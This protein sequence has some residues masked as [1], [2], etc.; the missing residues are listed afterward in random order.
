MLWSLWGYTDGLSRRGTTSSP[1]A[2]LLNNDI[3]TAFPTSLHFDALQL[4]EWELAPPN[5]DIIIASPPF[6]LLDPFL[7]EFLMRA[8]LFVCIHTPSDYI[9]N[10]PTYRRSLWNWYQEAGLTAELRGLPR[11]KA[12]NTRRCSWLIIFKISEF[13]KRFWQASVDCFTLCT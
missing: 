13:K 10:G 4:E 9:A 6:Q 11:V 8:S 12:R 1:R 7:G 3:N 5:I 2:L